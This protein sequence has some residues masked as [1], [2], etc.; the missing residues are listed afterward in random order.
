MTEKGAEGIFLLIRTQ[1]L[2]IP[3]PDPGQNLFDKNVKG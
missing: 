2:L 1:T 3:A